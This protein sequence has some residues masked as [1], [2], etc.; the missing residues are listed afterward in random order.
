MR[1]AAANPNATRH[2]PRT[3]LMC[4]ENRHKQF[5]F[6]AAV[7]KLFDYAS[8]ANLL[9]TLEGIGWCSGMKLMCGKKETGKSEY[10]ER[11]PALPRGVNPKD[12]V[13]VGLKE[14]SSEEPDLTDG[15]CITF[16]LASDNDR[17]CFLT[18]LCP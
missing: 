6:Q 17:S 5:V 16:K 9:S 1:V 11:L 15:G 10:H 4:Y 8:Q 18:C 14:G 12:G 2:K 13:W 7:D 3:L